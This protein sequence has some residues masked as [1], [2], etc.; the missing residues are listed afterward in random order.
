[1]PETSPK[2]Y[3][4]YS[5]S[6]WSGLLDVLSGA[7]NGPNPIRSA[8]I[9]QRRPTPRPKT[10]RPRQC[11]A[12]SNNT[13]RKHGRKNRS[14]PNAEKK[15]ADNPSASPTSKLPIKT[16]LDKPEVL[17]K[18]P[19]ELRLSVIEAGSFSGYLCLRHPCIEVTTKC[20]RAVPNIF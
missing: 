13:M 2:R 20:C 17:D 14:T 19:Q 4:R 6:F 5:G 12:P 1:M 16:V 3:R 15:E 10:H 7:G 18:L 8:P 11:T 9:P